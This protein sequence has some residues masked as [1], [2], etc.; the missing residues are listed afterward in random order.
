MSS[1]LPFTRLL[2]QPLA[3][4]ERT[5]SSWKKAKHFSGEIRLTWSG[6]LQMCRPIFFSTPRSMSMGFQKEGSIAKLTV[7][8]DISQ[9]HGFSCAGYS[10][11]AFL[12]G[13]NRTVRHTGA[14]PCNNLASI[15]VPKIK[16]PLFE[17]LP[18]LNISRPVCKSN[19]QHEPH[20]WFGGW[21]DDFLRK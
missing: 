7:F 15:R 20:L 12:G 3:E 2:P 21:D 5:T 10:L 13:I 16:I 14:H 19:F 1:W 6:L 9:G 18:F 8:R 4:Q 17:V 11:S